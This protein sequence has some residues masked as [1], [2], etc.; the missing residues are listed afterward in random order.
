MVVVF[1][2]LC[3]TIRMFEPTNWRLPLIDTLPSRWDFGANRISC[4]YGV[5]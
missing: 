5:F 1:V 4:E 2:D 3:V